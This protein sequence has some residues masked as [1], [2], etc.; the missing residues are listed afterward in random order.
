MTIPGCREN[1]FQFARANHRVNFRN[2]LL[3]LVAE[4]FDQAAR[5]HQF[6]G[7]AGGLVLGH[8]QDGVYRF[9]LGAG[10]KR[11]GVD[12]DH[13]GFFGAGDQ[14]RPGL[15]EHAHHD[16]AIHEVFGA[17]QAYKANFRR[18]HGGWR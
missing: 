18:G 11:A 1:S 13:V 17:P 15:G 14:C 4:T 12:H 9:L 10:D 3:N 16:L 6:L 8:L 2:V 5:N 7:A